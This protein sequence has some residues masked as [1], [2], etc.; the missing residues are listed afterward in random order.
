MDAEQHYYERLRQFAAETVPPGGI[1]LLGSSHLEWF[2]AP[3]LLPGRHFVN[4]GIASDRLG[5][6]ERG[7]LHRLDVSLVACRPAFIVFENGANDLGELWRHG[8]PTLRAI[9]ACYDRVVTEIRTRCAGVPLLLI[10]V[11]PTTGRYAGLNPHV[12][13]FNPHVARIA[14]A[15]TCAHLD[16][17]SAMA[18]ESGELRPELTDDG[19]HLNALGY[20]LFAEQIAPHLPPPAIYAGP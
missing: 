18:D 17:W 20:R 1:L 6:T 10:N 14:V 7:I 4:R 5:L 15:H 8:I 2:D 12:R 11:M 16:L 19:L 13:Q 3:H 9:I